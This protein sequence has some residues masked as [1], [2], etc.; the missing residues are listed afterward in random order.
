MTE[1]PYIDGCKYDP[2]DLR[3]D[4]EDFPICQ[5]GWRR[6]GWRSTS[7]GTSVDSSQLREERKVFRRNYSMKQQARVMHGQSRAETEPEKR[8]LSAQELAGLEAY[9]PGEDGL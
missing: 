5:H 2:E 7:K 8:K 6:Y 3:F 4:D 1:F 9:S